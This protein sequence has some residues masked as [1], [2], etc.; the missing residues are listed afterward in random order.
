MSA[1]INDGGP[2]YPGF[3]Y[4]DGR[5]PVKMT[6]GPNGLEWQTYHPGMTLRDAIAL[7]A[8][9]SLIER[10]GKEPAVRMM[11]TVADDA[12]RLREVKL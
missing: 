12:M 3:Q 7:A 9:P 5:G 1:P 2:A 4:T 10:Y 11:W 8:L 6:D